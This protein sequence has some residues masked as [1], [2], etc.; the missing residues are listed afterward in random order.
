MMAYNENGQTLRDH[1]SRLLAI[2]LQHAVDGGLRSLNRA[3]IAEAG[4]VSLGVV[5]CAL[6]KRDEMTQ[7]VM[8][9]ARAQGVELKYA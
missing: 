6:G 9:T 2:A 1:R 8:D 7:L 5:S 4:G 3:K